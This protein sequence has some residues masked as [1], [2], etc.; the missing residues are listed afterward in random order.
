MQNIHRKRRHHQRRVTRRDLQNRAPRRN[1]HVQ[2]RN[3]VFLRVRC[4]IK[5]RTEEAHDVDVG[6]PDVE[7]SGTEVYREHLA[8]GSV[9]VEVH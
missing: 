2:R 5:Q 4:Q 7:T 3:P 9:V 6:L 1:A 8:D